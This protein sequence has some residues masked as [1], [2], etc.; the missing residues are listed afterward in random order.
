[1]AEIIGNKAIEDAAIAWVIERE[2]AAGRIPRDTR[3]AGA[4][5]DIESPPRVI[6]VK[7]FG[8][9]NRGY[10]LWLEPRQCQEARNNPNFYLYIVEN[11][12]QGDST[13]FTLKVLG[14]ERLRHLMERAKEQRYFTVPWPVADYDSC[15]GD[16]GG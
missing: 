15:P 1:M 8:K 5:S 3:F 11:V 6:E 14:G 2:R 10:D 4:P 13:Q 12:R 16:L 9:S 7:A